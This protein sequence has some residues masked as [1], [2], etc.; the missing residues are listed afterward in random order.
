MGSVGD[1][2]DAPI[3]SL[4]IRGHVKTL[5]ARKS[6]TLGSVSQTG[7]SDLTG[8][9]GALAEGRRDEVLAFLGGLQ[10]EARHL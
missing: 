5:Q 1:F 2:Y 3:Q 8:L 6:W 9:R 10:P 4:W 7:A